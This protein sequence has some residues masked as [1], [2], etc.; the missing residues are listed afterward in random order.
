M[1]F[2]VIALMA[3]SGYGECFPQ[4][5]IDGSKTPWLIADSQSY[6][7]LFSILSASAGSLGAASAR[8]RLQLPLESRDA[9]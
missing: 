2:R 9:F 5:L 1:I 4:E 7:A 3:M 8:R 6:Q